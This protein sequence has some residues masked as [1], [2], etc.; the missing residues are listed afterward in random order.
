M[1]LSRISSRLRPEHLIGAT[2][3]FVKFNLSPRGR[4]EPFQDSQEGSDFFL[5]RVDKNYRII[6]VERETQFG[7]SSPQGGQKPVLSC[8]IQ[9]FLQGVDGQ[10]E[11]IGGKRVTLPEF[12]RMIDLFTWD[13][14]QQYCGV[15]SAKKY[16][17]PVSPTL[18]EAPVL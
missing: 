6:S 1:K 13:A 9:D 10:D 3:H 7:M 8:D 16:G 2:T 5:D 11:E 18:T 15:G 14:I 12:P 17:Q 4:A